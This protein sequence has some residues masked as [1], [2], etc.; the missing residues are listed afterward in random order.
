LARLGNGGIGGAF[1][2]LLRLVILDVSVAFDDA[3]LRTEFC[4]VFTVIWSSLRDILSIFSSK[5]VGSGA[6]LFLKTVK[7]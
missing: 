7:F 4:S 1:F 3:E 2:G 5:I 6:V